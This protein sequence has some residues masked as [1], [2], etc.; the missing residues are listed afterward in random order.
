MTVAA[1]ILA[2]SS[3]YALASTEGVPR[4]RRLADTSWSGGA[5][6]I[7]VVAP[8]PDGLVAR[9]LAGAPVTL[10]APAPT[11]AGP[12][13]QIV[14]GIEA[15]RAEV[16]DTDGVLIWP[17]RMAWIDPETLTSLIEAHG[18]T[19]E[20]LLRP[21]YR[22]EPGWPVLLPLEQ[23]ERLRGLASDR[24]PDELVVDLL[25]SGLTERRIEL[26]DP[27][28]THDDSVARSNLPPYDGPPGPTAG[29]AHEWGAPIADQPDEAPIEGFAPY[30]S[31]SA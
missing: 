7:I 25:A 5:V 16:T 4:V 17:A 1:V 30:E 14:C 13:G 26:G 21:T 31:S 15:A 22:D 11:D 24:M 8:D 27:G 2:A 6:P 18:V 9:A 19:P 29:H 28:V 10:A 3:E 20:P 23:L 12:I